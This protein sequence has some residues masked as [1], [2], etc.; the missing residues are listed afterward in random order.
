MMLINKPAHALIEYKCYKCGAILFVHPMQN[1]N[2]PY[3]ADCKLHKKE[4]FT[5]D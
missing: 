4:T 2:S 5:D 3:L 1:T